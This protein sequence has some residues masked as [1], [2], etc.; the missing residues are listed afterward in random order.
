MEKTIY[1]LM[2]EKYPSMSKGQKRITDFIKA[3]VD[4]AA[5]MTAAKLGEAAEVSEST[6][7]RY[8]MALGFDGYPEFQEELANVVRSTLG[9]VQ[10][11]GRLYGKSSQSDL[12]TAV[13]GADIE[14]IAD[15]LEMI[16]VNVFEMAVEAISKARNI[17]VVGIRQ[18]APLAGLAGFYLNMMF[19]NVRQIQSTA[20]NEIFEQMIGVSS[21]DVVI[22]ISFPRYSLRT[23]KAMEFANNRSA[24]II[25]ITD[26]KNSP[27]NMYSSINLWARSD[28]I[29]IVDSLVGPLSLINALIIALCVKCED[30]VNDNLRILEGVW[31]D[32]RINDNDNINHMNNVSQ[33]VENINGRT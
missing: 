14:R 13:L 6:A 15:T 4:Q 24:K 8:A 33:V 32:Y 26:G 27:M 23:L 5:F 25:A 9:G 22:G 21:E 17:Y 20:I 10:Q 2:D 18:E 30:R 28:S 19:G 7:V 31:G 29:S 12:L 11:L 1:E 3:N 16:D